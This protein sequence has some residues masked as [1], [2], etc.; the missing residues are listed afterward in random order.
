MALESVIQVPI[1]L[2]VYY[3]PLNSL[4][5]SCQVKITKTKLILTTHSV[6]YPCIG[7]STCEYNKQQYLVLEVLVQSGIGAALQ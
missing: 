7:I 3:K 2:L 1:L 5:Q 6:V 4:F